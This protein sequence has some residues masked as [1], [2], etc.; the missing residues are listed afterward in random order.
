MGEEM[1]EEVIGAVVDQYGAEIM[2]SG[3]SKE[4]AQHI[5]LSGIKNFEAKKRSRIDRTGRLRYTAKMST[6]RRRNKLLGKTNWFKGGKDK[7]KYDKGSKKSGKANAKGEVQKV[8]IKA[9]LFCDFTKNGELATSLR[10]LMRGMERTLG[11]GIKVVERTG[12]T[13]RS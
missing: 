4:E 6:R 1:G 3:F 12:P 8:E 5:L 7:V 13:L 2:R 10:E 9:V 11:F